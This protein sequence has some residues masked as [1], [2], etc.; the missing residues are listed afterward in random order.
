MVV[1]HYADFFSY[2]GSLLARGCDYM[3][4][5]L[6]L[7]HGV[8]KPRRQAVDKDRWISALA[9]GARRAGHSLAAERLIA[10][11]L[12]EI[13]FAYYGDL[14]AAAHRQGAEGIALTQQEAELLHALLT[15]ITEAQCD[16]HPN[17]DG[18]PGAALA[19]AR[20]QL[21]LGETGT[22]QGA[23]DLVRQSINAAT[24][25]LGARPWYRAGQWVGGKF[26]VADLAQAARYLSRGEP[27][28]AGQT[29]DARIRAAVA[30]SIGPDPAV[31]IAHSL[32]TVVGFEALHEP[33]A[34]VPLFVTLGSPLAMRAVVWPRV[35]PR[36]PAT[37]DRVDRWLNFWDRD[38]IIVPR[39]ILES[40]VAANA[41]GVL[42]ESTRTDADGVWT[43][44]A[45]KYLAKPD[46]A[47]PVM[48]ALASTA[49]CL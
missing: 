44:T 2:R 39:P 46:V 8:G 29:L 9:D 42:P 17:D 49:A 33:G 35:R 6:V 7:V 20:A 47:G 10:G 12:A 34:R 23:G 15:E 40:D 43:H 22:A 13:V 31:V 38:D 48:E 36:P 19:S 28:P 45:T 41:A 16:A 26:L 3:A 1:Y 14:F 5:R 18:Q 32:G 25:L 27:D 4:P 11:E 21:R 30:A 37:P 24:T